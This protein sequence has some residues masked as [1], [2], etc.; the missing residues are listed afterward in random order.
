[1]AQKG[2]VKG[3]PSGAEFL[4]SDSKGLDGPPLAFILSSNEVQNLV[5]TVL[6]K[7]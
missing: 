3:Y 4:L 6:F 5:L 7:A 1:L 2:R